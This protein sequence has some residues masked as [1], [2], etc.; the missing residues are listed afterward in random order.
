MPQLK[1][2]SVDWVS[3]VDRAAVRDP[4]NKSEPRRFLLSKREGAQAPEN[5]IRKDG[6]MPDDKTPEE[7]AAALTK[8]EQDAERVKKEHEAELAKK[9][10]EHDAAIKKAEEERDAA[11]AKAD[12]KKAPVKGDGDGDDDEPELSKAAQERLKKA[13]DEVAELRKSAEESQ[14][15]AKDERDRRV[16]AEFIT[17]AEAYSSLPIQATEFGPVLKRAAEK[18]EKSDFEAL[19]QLLTAANEQ[20][21]KGALFAQLGSD[22]GGSAVPAGAY[23]E[24]QQ[25][26]DQLRKS[27]GKLSKG[28]AEARVMSENPDLQARYLAEM[29]G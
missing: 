8:A 9:Q 20:V 7:L 19:E 13:E 29:R 11:I 6:T 14:T 24:V 4:Q 2:L 10:E 15:I 28:E 5:T 12:P 25:K 23:A 16:T 17:K 27:D 1:D 21:A 26:A 3:L 22:V 18:L